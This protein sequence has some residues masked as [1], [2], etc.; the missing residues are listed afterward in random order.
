MP[1]VASTNSPS[2]TP[3]TR[4]RTGGHNS[5]QNS[6]EEL[7]AKIVDLLLIFFF[8]YMISLVHTLHY[9]NIEILYLHLVYLLSTHENY[10]EM[11]TSLTTRIIRTRTNLV[12]HSSE[13]NIDL[14]L[15]YFQEC[16]IFIPFNKQFDFLSIATAG[17]WSLWA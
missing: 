16:E 9:G 11:V 7:F 8:L 13:I 17:P 4:L 15:K 2:A 3:T 1:S 10:F 14:I 6:Q 5:G 12:Y